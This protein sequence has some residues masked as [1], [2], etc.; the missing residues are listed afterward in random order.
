MEN[1]INPLPI[2]DVCEAHLPLVIIIDNSP[3]MN[4]ERLDSLDDSLNKFI[5][6][7]RKDEYRS[8]TVDIL[9]VNIFN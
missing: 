2:L 3:N 6:T 9:R 5:D 8:K 4:K 1:Q 7:I